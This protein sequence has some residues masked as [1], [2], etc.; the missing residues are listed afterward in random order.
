MLKLMP[1]DL[2]MLSHLILITVHKVVLSLL[3]V[4]HLR[5]GKAGI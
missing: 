1:L 2:F 4:M 3:K 5:V